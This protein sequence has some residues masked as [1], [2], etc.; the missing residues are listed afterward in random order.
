MSRLADFYRQQRPDEGSLSDNEI[1]YKYYAS[2][3][4][5]WMRENH[6]QDWRQLQDSI[7]KAFP[8]SFGEELS[9][10]WTR[11]VEGLKSTYYGGK[12]FAWDAV[13]ADDWRDK[14]IEWYQEHSQRASDPATAARDPDSWGALV[15][16]AAPSVGESLV[17]AGGGALA[18]SMLTPGIDPTDVAAAP[19]G[20]IAGVVRKQAIKNLMR[21]QFGAKAAKEAGIGALGSHLVKS[22]PSAATSQLASR[23]GKKEAADLVQA[24][25]KSIM[26]TSGGTLAS[27]GNSLGLNTGGIYGDL[28]SDPDIDP[29]DAFNI[30]LIGGSISAIPDSVLPSYVA[31]KLMRSIYSKPITESVKRS[32]YQKIANSFPGR[33]TRYMGGAA[34]WEGT[35]EFFQEY[36]HIISRKV[37]EGATLS[38]AIDAPLSYDE[39]ERM[40]HAFKV[41]AVAGGMSGGV[42]TGAS[43]LS[44]ADQSDQSDQTGPSEPLEPDIEQVNKFGEMFGGRSAK[45]GELEVFLGT[46]TQE[47]IAEVDEILS[48]EVADWTVNV[49]GEVTNQS[50]AIVAEISDKITNDGNDEAK[51]SY[52]Y[53][54]R[55]EARLKAAQESAVRSDTPKEGYDEKGGTPPT[56]DQLKSA[57][58]A[59]NTA[60]SDHNNDT[61]EE[62]EEEAEADPEAQWQKKQAWAQK[63]A[64]AGLA[65]HVTLEVID[66]LTALHSEDKEIS[67]RWQSELYASKR[68]QLVEL[69][70][71]GISTIDDIARATTILNDM[72]GAMMSGIDPNNIKDVE[73]VSDTFAMFADTIPVAP[74]LVSKYKEHTEAKN[75]KARKWKLLRPKREYR[76]DSIW[77]GG[78]S[79]DGI[80]IEY[81]WDR[82]EHGQPYHH[83]DTTGEVAPSRRADLLEFLGKGIDPYEI[84][85]PRKRPFPASGKK[86]WG[87]FPEEM[88]P[89]ALALKAAKQ[90]KKNQ[91]QLV[92]SLPNEAQV[93]KANADIDSRIE[94][95]EK[96]LNKVEAEI[97]KANEKNSEDLDKLAKN[98]RELQEKGNWDEAAEAKY[99]RDV[100]KLAPSETLTLNLLR[101]KQEI[102]NLNGT[103]DY[104]EGQFLQGSHIAFQT[105][106]AEKQ[107]TYSEP[108]DQGEVEEKK[109]ERPRYPAFYL[110][111]E[112][113]IAAR[114]LREALRVS[115]EGTKEE[116]AE[117]YEKLGDI[118]TSQGRAKGRKESLSSR[119]VI[120]QDEDGA[121]HVLSIHKKNKKYLVTLPVGYPKSGRKK[122]VSLNELIEKN[123]SVKGSIRLLFER[124]EVRHRVP[125]EE[126]NS[127]AKERIDERHSQASAAVS[128][129]RAE[130]GGKTKALDAHDEEGGELE[131]YGFSEGTWT[132]EGAEIEA[133]RT[134]NTIVEAIQEQLDKG[135]IMPEE[136][137]PFSKKTK[138]WV[139]SLVS[140][141]ATTNPNISSEELSYAIIGSILSDSPDP[142]KKELRD[143]YDSNGK[144][145]GLAAAIG[146]EVY[147]ARE[148]I[149]P[150]YGEQEIKAL[151]GG[152]EK[153][154]GVPEGAQKRENEESGGASRTTQRGETDD[155]V[156]PPPPS[157]I[158][159]STREKIDEDK[160]AETPTAVEE[161]GP[162]AALADAIGRRNIDWVDGELRLPNGKPVTSENVEEIIA[163]L[164]EDDKSRS[165]YGTG[166]EGGLT[167]AEAEAAVRNMPDDVD[168]TTL[169][170][171]LINDSRVTTKAEAIEKFEASKADREQYRNDLRLALSVVEGQSSTTTPLESKAGDEEFASDR[172]AMLEDLLLRKK[173]PIDVVNGDTGE[174]ILAAGRKIFKNRLAKLLQAHDHV[175]EL[176][177]EGGTEEQIQEWRSK[178]MG[179]LS[180]APLESRIDGGNTE[181]EINELENIFLGEKI[182]AQIFHADTGEII[183][184]GNKTITRDMLANLHRLRDKLDFE[185]VPGDRASRPQ[186][187]NEVRKKVMG[188]LEDKGA[189]LF[190]TRREENTHGYIA[191]ERNK[192][193]DGKASPEDVAFA[194]SYNLRQE[195]TEGAANKLSAFENAVRNGADFL[196]E[197]H[198]LLEGLGYRKVHS[199]GEKVAYNPLTEEDMVGGM[200]PGDS[201][202]V[203]EPAWRGERG[204]VRGRVTTESE[205]EVA[206]DETDREAN[207]AANRQLVE[208]SFLQGLRQKITGRI[209]KEVNSINEMPEGDESNLGPLIDAVKRIEEVLLETE[210]LPSKEDPYTRSFK[211]IEALPDGWGKQIRRSAL[212]G[213]RPK[214]DKGTR[215]ELDDL[216]VLITRDDLSSYGIAL[217]KAKR[218][219]EFLTRAE[220]LPSSFGIDPTRRA[221]LAS[222]NEQEIVNAS[223]TPLQTED[224]IGAFGG[225]KYNPETGRMEPVEVV[226]TTKDAI[227]HNV[228]ASVSHVSEAAPEVEYVPSML[229]GLTDDEA[230]AVTKGIREKINGTTEGAM[231]M[232]EVLLQSE[233]N[234]E[235]GPDAELT[236]FEKMFVK[237]AAFLRAHPLLADV[238]WK[239]AKGA[240][241]VKDP[242]GSYAGTTAA[243]YTDHDRTI[244]LY[245][246]HMTSRRKLAADLIHEAI[247]ALTQ[248]LVYDFKEGGGKRLTGRQ[249][250]AL[251]KIDRLYKKA[252]KIYSEKN[253]GKA[254]PYA[255]S[256]LDEFMAHVMSSRVIIQTLANMEGERTDTSLL[257]DI[258]NQL[259][260]LILDVLEAV[261]GTEVLLGPEESTTLD[262]TLAGEA[263][264]GIL[265][266][267][268]ASKD[269]IEGVSYQAFMNMVGGVKAGPPATTLQ[270]IMGGGTTV[271]RG[272]DVDNTAL[273][274]T[275]VATFNALDKVYK[276]MYEHWNEMGMNPTGV[277][278]EEFV[279]LQLGTDLP[280]TRINDI[281]KALIKVGKATIDKGTTID[282][283]TN[284]ERVADNTYQ[285]L[286]RT[287]AKM[288]NS[289]NKAEETVIEA[290]EKFDQSNNEL[291]SIRKNYMA[292]GATTRIVATSLRNFLDDMKRTLTNQHGV[293]F[294]IITRTHNALKAY[295]EDV[296]L[297]TDKNAVFVA[298]KLTSDE[299]L[300]FEA[301]SEL[302]ELDINFAG[303]SHSDLAGYVDD[304]LTKMDTTLDRISS[305]QDVKAA[306]A[307]LLVSLAKTN[308]FI[309]DLIQVRN[310]GAEAAMGNKERDAINNAIKLAM[311]ADVE[312][313]SNARRAVGSVQTHSAAA[314]RILSHLTKK[315]NEHAK[316]L[317]DQKKAREFIDMDNVTRKE[318]DFHMARLEESLDAEQAALREA[319][320]G[321]KKLLADAHQGFLYIVPTN[322]DIPSRD[323]LNVKA[324][325]DKGWIQVLYMS[326]PKDK[327]GKAMSRKAYLGKLQRDLAAMK[328][329]LDKPG[330]TKDKVYRFIK[331]SYARIANE[332]VLHEYQ[333]R[334]SH[335]VLAVLGQFQDWA[336]VTGNPVLKNAGARISRFWGLVKWSEQAEPLAREWVIAEANAKRA[337]GWT[338]EGSTDAIRAR[339]HSVALSYFENHQ[340]LL[341]NEGSVEAAITKG[342]K[343]LRQQWIA[344][345]GEF[346]TK[347]RDDGTWA[348]VEKYIR[349]TGKISSKLVNIQEEM[350]IKVLDESGPYA[351][352]RKAIGAELF[353]VARHM[354]SEIQS[355]VREMRAKWTADG[356]R[357]RKPSDVEVESAE[358]Y[359]KNRDALAGKWRGMVDQGSWRTFVGDL[360][361]KE[362][363]G[364]F[365]SAE[366]IVLSEDKLGDPVLDK[367]GVLASRTE[368]IEA[369]GEATTEEG[370]DPVLFAELLYE[371]TGGNMADHVTK[372]LY[373]AKTLGQLQRKYNGLNAHINEASSPT[374]IN[375]VFDNSPRVMMD[376]RQTEGFPSSWMSYMTYEEHQVTATIRGWAAQ[377]A[378]GTDMSGM[379]SDLSTA[380][381]IF[382]AQDDMLVKIQGEADEAYGVNPTAKKQRWIENE[383]NKRALNEFGIKEGGYKILSEA[384]KNKK[385]LETF[386][387]KV[388]S[389]MRNEA[390]KATLE[391]SSAME[392]L[393]SLAGIA[394]QAVKTAIIDTSALAVQPVAKAGVRTGGKW[395]ARNLF[396]FTKQIVGSFLQAMGRQIDLEAGW[397]TKYSEANLGDPDNLMEARDRVVAAL[398]REVP[399]GTMFPGAVKTARFVSEF[400]LRSGFVGWGER[401]AKT[402]YT[403]LKPQAVFTMASMWMHG[404]NVIGTWK[405]YAELVKKAA[406][407]LESNPKAK[408]N[409]DYELSHTDVGMD[410]TGFD[411][412]KGMLAD[413]GMR[414]EALARNLNSGKEL[415]GDTEIFTNH[416]LRLLA[417]LAQTEITKETSPLTRPIWVYTTE[418]GRWANPL[419]GWSLEKTADIARNFKTRDNAGRFSYKVALRSMAPFTVVLPIT[420]AYAMIR[421]E[422]EEEWLGKKANRLDFDADKDLTHNFVAFVDRANVAGTFGIAG[423]AANSLINL[424]SGRQFSIENRVFFLSM[425]T[426]LLTE[427]WKW[428]GR[429]MPTDYQHMT[430]PLIQSLAGG[431]LLEF[432]QATDGAF[433]LAESERQVTRRINVEN[434]L[435]S[436]GRA[437]ELDVRGF[438][439]SQTR[440][441]VKPHVRNMAIHAMS[442]DPEAFWKA[443][444]SALKEAN[445]WV[446][447]KRNYTI[448][449]GGRVE[450]DKTVHEEA[451]EYVRSSFRD[452]HPLR[453]IFVTMPTDMQ[454]QMLLNEIPGDHRMDIKSAID[455]FNS[456]GERI[457]IEP[458]Q[459]KT[460][461]KSTRRRLK[462]P[463]GIVSDLLQK[464][465]REIFQK[466][467]GY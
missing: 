391:Y 225:Y 145:A 7:N 372:A 389:L 196:E 331:R 38:D 216:L 339:V 50:P 349:T 333:S 21:D 301:L 326:P 318:L 442:N 299:D 83:S 283:I 182:R 152:Q 260:I 69:L 259:K 324:N 74:G 94:F 137:P 103:R 418:L 4:E 185:P 46:M 102:E 416:Q 360:A 250:D 464:R 356:N 40:N 11:G 392:L 164:D 89:F 255:F 72:R 124:E 271:T 233:A 243:E 22:V 400:F 456:Y 312:A 453:K 407:A 13:G 218:I 280:S 284:K 249:R 404:A 112:D 327:H 337:L 419:L 434:W 105:Q 129:D 24:E 269:Q 292:A 180:P 423:D 355:V 17:V 276:S 204:V 154:G 384:K 307:S 253:Q 219:I 120:L 365:M 465:R 80:N 161:T 353:T 345:G 44:P 422:W 251:N 171:V 84:P 341:E 96:E 343:N 79:F 174:I 42:V 165:T 257:Q 398:N 446:I 212:Q 202:V 252:L 151:G 425:V 296:P 143:Y 287:K 229:D 275:Q 90:K 466:A 286:S 153:R 285:L 95:L 412:M 297:N 195:A 363:Q 126:F 380:K 449:T 48:R 59:I 15:G 270:S 177:F 63:R 303:S 99:S 206:V 348:A 184:P 3:G 350:G 76:G 228:N 262:R 114:D 110:I 248:R 282:S 188:V 170:Q 125:R 109:L 314:E 51:R 93:A 311:S 65:T 16:E 28:A 439:K 415:K 221:S 368:A 435:R 293:T 306:A 309:L 256:S 417:T 172:A 100:S 88:S 133:K 43:Y 136:L 451:V 70:E 437:L 31:G 122:N 167:E 85:A 10:G 41:G 119:L 155:K 359:S 313:L 409:S 106:L 376:A 277:S 55:N 336:N 178:I 305:D 73:A 254:T 295:Q 92:P 118:L 86:E 261:K 230:N 9:R 247:H 427:A 462:R 408:R 108:N 201:A 20:A 386:R 210:V 138:D 239:I 176:L 455:M 130:A 289:R 158:S 329:W 211:T 97:N 132:G 281:N 104:E 441:T 181:S 91:K 134:E 107:E 447:E 290:S 375:N 266:L 215:G 14:N 75:W 263:I 131:T 390:S 111:D 393:G 175:S 149:Q 454:Y 366:D 458:L 413:Q 53:K 189:F 199:V 52:Y 39:V 66:S 146:R 354:S 320:G 71:K 381:R 330:R 242:E 321:S 315:K 140:A 421:E 361:A 235:M 213:L 382:E 222:A 173:I 291:E 387:Q 245:L 200:I 49:K 424:T 203:T 316:L 373:V 445:E 127:W 440:N 33:V 298:D 82:P 166:V 377:A 226:P 288:V 12:A 54:Q 332:V 342:L 279:K 67:K 467:T 420:L 198:K 64:D 438:Y 168:V 194:M 144:T 267:G 411:Y 357:R 220:L 460:E 183:I 344:A 5:A 217:K 338:S 169:Q 29:D 414:L 187:A 101:I 430:R 45:P 157:V 406:D 224:V 401:G 36:V 121:Y 223:L 78:G 60:A 214:V 240:R 317:R 294:N 310:M 30:S 428:K 77:S 426:G 57:F 23:Y 156:K 340:E 358:E 399:P 452:Q 37:A 394:V 26:A 448:R 364:V 81:F 265:V 302:S 163:R 395:S 383:A 273:N 369:W 117:A 264:E 436:V 227:N 139:Y 1:L 47:E 274:K 367:V 209:S 61:K 304:V 403:T 197:L 58:N 68:K 141:S 370:G 444:R 241:V 192:V 232:V 142:V 362:G 246:Y 244:T 128:L 347:I 461:K 162:P 8:L 237:I 6:P 278:Y 410:K 300:L 335:T 18:A 113:T 388:S 19:A 328:A 234:M 115:S 459:G 457:G 322:P 193:L 374:S 405:T 87:E 432:L 32:T 27:F 207:T 323:L 429:G 135:E 35:T 371:K 159:R 123:Y 148:K 319:A 231:G 325:K 397:Q 463:T 431:G 25:M 308:Q 334:R 450:S 268:G 186:D 351:Y 147:E 379:D 160:A 238:K 258:W 205:I 98:R 396:G 56:E 402:R 352:F 208:E 236:S 433:G 179:I 346:G 116:A 272:S 190:K 2:K 62:A 191:V 378:L 150:G 385:S 443:H 34:G